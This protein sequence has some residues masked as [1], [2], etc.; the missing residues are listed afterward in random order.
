MAA[1]GNWLRAHEAT[2]PGTIDVARIA[3]GS[4]LANEPMDAR[5]LDMLSAESVAFRSFQA[6]DAGTVWVFLGYFARQKEGSQVHSP[7]HCYPGSGWSIQ[8]AG[9]IDAPWGGQ[10]PRLV[11]SDGT[12]KRLVMYWYQT[13]GG[14]VDSVLDLKLHLTGRVLAGQAPEVVFARVSTRLEGDDEAA[15][16]RVQGFAGEV[17]EQIAELYAERQTTR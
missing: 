6:R 13:P 2:S 3:P 5:F 8:E 15:F 11:V 9:K 1:A 14:I 17:H 10:A 12:E 7:R 16:E 4:V